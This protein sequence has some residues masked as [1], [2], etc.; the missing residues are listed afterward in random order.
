[1]PARD[2]DSET[3][4]ATSLIVVDS[5]MTFTAPYRCVWVD[6]DDG[7][8]C[9]ARLTGEHPEPTGTGRAVRAPVDCAA[10]R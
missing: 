5:L 7:N 6:V 10:S 1:M 4:A 8:T 3:S 9:A 2:N